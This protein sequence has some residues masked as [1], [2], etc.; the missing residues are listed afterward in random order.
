MIVIN[1]YKWGLEMHRHKR[2]PAG[3]KRKSRPT[4]RLLRT[5]KRI[6]AGLAGIVLAAS[7]ATGCISHQEKAPV[8]ARTVKAVQAKKAPK[9]AEQPE[10]MGK[11]RYRTSFSIRTIKGLET[12]IRYWSLVYS[13][14][15]DRVIIAENHSRENLRMMYF[16]ERWR[17]RP[18]KTREANIDREVKKLIESLNKERKCLGKR[19]GCIKRKQLVFKLGKRKVMAEGVLRYTEWQQHLEEIFAEK[20]LPPYLGAIMIVESQGNPNAKSELG[21]LGPYQLMPWTIERF[22]LY[23]DGHKGKNK[24]GE[25]IWVDNSVDERRN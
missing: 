5:K 19:K 6:M 11:V 9:K 4:G 15:L 21:A 22:K 25:E 18:P 14:P 8:E 24:K 23:S 2:I 13:K 12:N 1:D 20:G 7:L 3:S 10:K 16:I 17:N